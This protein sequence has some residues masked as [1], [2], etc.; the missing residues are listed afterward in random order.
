MRNL[1]T[2]AFLIA[3]ASALMADGTGPFSGQAAK[4]EYD[5]WMYPH[6]PGGTRQTASVY[7]ALPSPASET[8]V[9]DRFAQFVLKFNTAGI[10]RPGL[11]ADNYH[12]ER[13]VLTAMVQGFIIYDPTEDARQ[14]SEANG[15]PDLDEGRPIEVHGT[16]FRGTATSANYNETSPFGSSSIHG[17]NAYAMGYSPEGVARD[18][19]HNVTEKFD[20]IPWGIG[21]ALARPAEG[22]PYEELQPGD[23]I[24]YNALIEFE[25]NLSLP[26]VAGYVR[27]SLNKGY[28]WLTI[29]SLHSTTQMAASGYPVFFTKENPE[30][31]LYGDAAAFLKVDYSLPIRILSFNRNETAGTAAI[32]W[33]GSPGFKYELQRSE[34]LTTN[35]W[36]PVNT[37]QPTTAASLT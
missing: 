11:G 31:A 26:G 17:R 27:E 21:R 10:A 34:N 35:S 32:S 13:V 19:S 22:E 23:N 1:A 29:S 16:G 9:E 28:I 4:P 8:G 37:Q 36:F 24:P 3:G 25:L 12:P 30:E 20:S 33:N 18:V 6:G 7:T 14:T 2:L 15:P 5:I